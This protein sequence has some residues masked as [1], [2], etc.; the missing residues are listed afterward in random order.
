[1]E[2]AGTFRNL[3][4]ESGP[5]PFVSQK[6]TLSS[7]HC[8]LMLAKCNAYKAWQ[9]AVPKELAVLQAQ[10]FIPSSV[11]GEILGAATLPRWKG[12]S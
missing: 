4:V 2:A 1:M 6:A 12:C 8:S 10:A 7:I 9:K 5:S 11:N 3:E